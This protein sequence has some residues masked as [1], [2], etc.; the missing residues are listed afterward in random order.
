MSSVRAMTT[1]GEG[2]T[3]WA[4]PITKNALMVVL[5]QRPPGPYVRDESDQQLV[6]LARA[7]D[8]DAFE[9]IVVRYRQQLLRHCRR[10]LPAA[11]AEDAVQDAFINA[12][13]AIGQTQGELQLG[14]W[15]FRIAHNAAVG[16]I[17]RR[18]ASAPL[19]LEE[20]SGPSEPVHDAVIRAEKLR[21][22]FDA[23]SA[24]PDAQRQA[25][26]EREL[27]GR[28]HHEI[29]MRLGRSEAAVRQLLNRARNQLRECVAAIAPLFAS[30]LPAGAQTE[31]T[32]GTLIAKAGAV[33]G[34]GLAATAGGIG[35]L[36]A[37]SSS[38]DSVHHRLAAPHEPS[39]AV[40][41]A[42]RP[43]SSA[44]APPVPIV[45]ARRER[46]S[47]VLRS[48][49]GS[50]RSHAEHHRGR[51]GGTG[52]RGHGGIR[53]GEGGSREGG[54][55]PGGSR[56]EAS[57]SSA[58]SGSSGSGSRDSGREGSGRS[59][60]GSSGTRSGSSDGGTSSS[61]SRSRSGDS[62]DESSG[63]SSS[64]SGS[65]ASGSSGTLLA[66]SDSGGSRSSGGL[67]SGSDSGGSSSGS[68][69]SGS[70][71]SGG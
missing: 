11:E 42:A 26:A 60:S 49:R 58:S 48:G 30:W 52:H 43:G 64:A 24:L 63:S 2:R 67:L 25:L 31:A 1:A 34:V 29:A 32:G 22:T 16:I 41:H 20:A 38:N 70:G 68:G 57:G 21:A 8:A 17:R 10:M 5:A 12:Y 61:G 19:D 40:R 6:E 53:H 4:R 18:V 37:V 65:N 28:G 54:R 66:G 3:E 23:M 9:A 27:A 69:L 14:A 15:L 7:G 33:V 45:S 13:R 55:P 36:S 47:F 59:R 71:S 44:T 62:S 50:G 56:H 51:G 46:D 39:R 35:A